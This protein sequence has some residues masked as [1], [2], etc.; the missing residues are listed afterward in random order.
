MQRC[1]HYVRQAAFLSISKSQTQLSL[2]VPSVRM[3]LFA[4][5]AGNAAPCTVPAV[6]RTAWHR[7]VPTG[8]SLTRY[9]ERKK[10]VSQMRNSYVL[11][12]RRSLHAKNLQ[13]EVKFIGLCS[14]T[15]MDI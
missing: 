4:A 3:M 8:V 14:V 13:M 7:S 10:G 1:A 5:A 11:S 6:R 12:V 2:H 9:T 15:G